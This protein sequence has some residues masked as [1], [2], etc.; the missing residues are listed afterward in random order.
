M[1]V[2]E[3]KNKSGA[4]YTKQVWKADPKRREKYLKLKDKENP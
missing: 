1:K 4:K 3:Y 2:K